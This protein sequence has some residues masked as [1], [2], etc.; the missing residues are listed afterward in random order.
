MKKSRKITV[1]IAVCLIAVGFI[2]ALTA[3]MMKGFN[4]TELNTMRIETKTYEIKEDFNDII[5]QSTNSEIDFVLSMDDQCKVVC[6]QADSMA[7]SVIAQDG[8]LKI[9]QKDS[10]KWYDYF[11]FNFSKNASLTIYLPKKEYNSLALKT[12]SA[13]ALVP[14]ELVFNEAQ[15]ASTSGDITFMANAKNKLLL[16]STS[17]DVIAENI[18][19]N[20]VEAKTT[21][22]EIFLSD[23][24]SSEIRANSTS[25][26]IKISSST[27]ENYAQLESTSGSVI[28]DGFDAEDL[29]I[30]TVS[31]NAKGTLLTPKDFTTNTVSGRIRVPSSQSGAGRCKISTTSGNISI[32]IK[33]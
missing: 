15:L 16:K 1:I 2:A 8:E 19:G 9:I 17:G 6:R 5:I 12:V 28:I 20:L 14:E 21:S 27:A 29:V 10:R 4:F 7:N 25:G 18:S 32:E 3:A 11:G 13:D 23:I 22:G 26:D 33:N 30:K 31:G 24:S